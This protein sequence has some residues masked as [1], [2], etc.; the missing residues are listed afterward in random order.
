MCYG[1]GAELHG[2]HLGDKRLDL[3]AEILIETLAASPAASINAACQG[4]AE[5]QAAYRLFDNNLVTPSKIIEP[6]IKATK[7]RIGEQPI[8]LLV[9]DTTEL[10]Y[11]K[12]PPED[13]GCLNKEDR[14]GLYDHSSVAFTLEGVCLGVLGVEFFSRT[15]ESLG[16][17]RERRGDP[18]ETKESF[19]W[20]EGYRLAC[21]VSREHP[22][23]HLISVADR[24]CDIY[25][26][27]LDAQQQELPAD[28]VI[29]AKAN[30]STPERDR[31]AGPAAYCKVR[32]QV[33]GSKLR[34]TRTIHL[35]RTPKRAARD[36]VLEFRAM[37]VTMKP[38][39][40]RSNLPGVR[41]NVVL[42]EEVSPPDDG[43]AVSWLLITSLPIRTTSD[44][45]FVAD[46][47]MGRWPI[48]IFFRVLKT[49][50][51]VEELQLETTTRLKNCLM[52][53]KIIAWRLLYVT[54]M[55]R[56]CPELSCDI[57]FADEEWQPVWKIACDEPIPEVAPR[58]SVF[59]AML[60][61]LGGYNNRPQDGPP[62]PQSIW[63]GLRRM[64]DF[65]L[66]WTTF[67]PGRKTES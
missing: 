65:S 31:T 58:L 62:G 64:T 56:A 45:L 8:V 17:T 33:A 35:P 67:G 63:I 43:T 28:F 51:R 42:I 14:F 41:V 61:E 23:T 4:W 66:A 10:D 50:C 6:H 12:H 27:F 13:A 26:I 55:G 57:L 34:M 38:P 18:I 46:V 32:D 20:L 37:A 5:T 59:I 39:H 15:A 48:E 19:R 16:K 60:A 1:I 49:G 44:I 30:R 53:Y 47:Y 54:Y 21:E 22:E 2:I 36:A 3:R 9:Q 11:T 40:A 7:K 29:R 25:D 24:E 52:F